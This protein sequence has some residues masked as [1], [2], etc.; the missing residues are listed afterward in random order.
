MLSQYVKNRVLILFIFLFNC[1]SIKAQIKDNI[2]RLIITNKDGRSTLTQTGFMYKLPSGQIGIFTA[3]H[4][5]IN[6]STII[7]QND[8]NE[9][10]TDLELDFVGIDDDVAFLTSK[11]ISKQHSFLKFGLPASSIKTNVRTLGYP[12]GRNTIYERRLTGG[13]ILSIENYGAL[14]DN[15]GS[16][17]RD[18]LLKRKSPSTSNKVL[19]I[20]GAIRKGDSGSPILNISNEVVG[21][22]DGGKEGINWAIALSTIKLRSKITEQSL[23]DE[24][25]KNNTLNDLYSETLGVILSGQKIPEE[26]KKKVNWRDKYSKIEDINGK[27]FKVEKHIIIEKNGCKY[28]QYFYGIV[29]KNGSEIVE[30]KYNDIAFDNQNVHFHVKLDPF[31]G[32]VDKYGGII[33]PIKFTEIQNLSD[34]F[35]KVANGFMGHGFL[36]QDGTVLASDFSDCRSFKEGMAAVQN[37]NGNWGYVNT[38]GELVIGYEYETASDFDS[39]GLAKVSFT[40]KHEYKKAYRYIKKD[41]SFYF[42]KY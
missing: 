4:G 33:I 22:I 1:D 36:K 35:Y 30:C 17:T 14:G 41:G 9:V 10:Y 11:N 32:V 38:R 19:F 6:Y 16:K 27:Y 13:D 12:L 31:L 21:M 28:S 34:G 18:L 5:V 39:D 23:I 24:I 25:S 20:V 15:V 29:E 8:F 26:E 42:P 40:P 7:A 37:N 2:F 3:L